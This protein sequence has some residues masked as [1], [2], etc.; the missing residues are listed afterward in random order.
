MN[1]NFTEVNIIGTWQ[2]VNK[3][4]IDDSNYHRIKMLISSYLVQI[5]S[6][7]D[8]WEKLFRDPRDSRYWEL[9]YPQS[10]LSGG[11]PPSLKCISKSDAK[12]KYLFSE[13]S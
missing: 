10:S 4:I 5:E 11:G 2:M 8:G 12:S 3:Q 6:S 13:N 1:I 7:E 9:T